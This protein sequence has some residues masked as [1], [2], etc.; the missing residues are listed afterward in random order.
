[1]ADINAAYA[2]LRDRMAAS[3]GGRRPLG[4][5]HTRARA[6]DRVGARHVPA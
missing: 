3:P 4:E 2:L 6:R 5:M 1:M